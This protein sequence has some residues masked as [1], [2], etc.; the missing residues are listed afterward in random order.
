MATSLL[1]SY[2]RLIAKA[3]QNYTQLYIIMS[4]GDSEPVQALNRCL[5]KDVP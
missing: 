1:L 3:M 2:L 4:P 5:E